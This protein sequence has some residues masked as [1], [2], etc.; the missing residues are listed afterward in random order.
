[1]YDNIKRIILSTVLRAF[2][3]FCF[4]VTMLAGTSAYGASNVD[5]NTDD[6]LMFQYTGHPVTLDA[7]YYTDG[8]EHSLGIQLGFMPYNSEFSPVV[9]L[10]ASK[11]NERTKY[12]NY[13]DNDEISTYSLGLGLNYADKGY[14][15]HPF[16][17]SAVTLNYYTV[18]NRASEYMGQSESVGFGAYAKT[19][20]YLI[21]ANRYGL[22]FGVA[23]HFSVIPKYRR[24]N[25]DATTNRK[26]QEY[27]KQTNHVRLF[28]GIISL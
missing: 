22:S 7:G 4:G 8:G 3:A 28:I 18:V 21:T 14:G 23:D 9:S 15:I 27:N 13:T 19:G 25:E 5:I 26:Y 16:F 12:D 2:G 20:L 1:M 24:Y 17:E 10:G 11:V 6:V